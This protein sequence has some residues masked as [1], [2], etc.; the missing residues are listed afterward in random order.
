MR[1]SELLLVDAVFVNVV[2]VLRTYFDYALLLDFW[3]G[4]VEWLWHVI[5]EDTWLS[6]VLSYD[7]D[8]RVDFCRGH[9]SSLMVFLFVLDDTRNIVD[10]FLGRLL[11]I[12]AGFN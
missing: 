5:V 12:L 4:R 9:N 10:R 1:A 3:E 7:H 2:S 11:C 8:Q 6:V